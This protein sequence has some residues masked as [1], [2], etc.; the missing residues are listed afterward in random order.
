[1]TAAMNAREIFFI[2]NSSQDFGLAKLNVLKILH[3]LEMA[4][5]SVAAY[6]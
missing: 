3:E 4:H 2:L 6:I 1:M 5:R